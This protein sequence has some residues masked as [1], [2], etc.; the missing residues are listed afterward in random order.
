MNR[1]KRYAHRAL[2]LLCLIKALLVYGPASASST[3]PVWYLGAPRGVDAAQLWCRDSEGYLVVLTIVNRSMVNTNDPEGVMC[4]SHNHIYGA[5]S[6]DEQS[7]IITLSLADYR[8]TVPVIMS[9]Y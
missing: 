6:V 5:T 4:R 9:A 8:V 1:Q 3:A 2:L 7:S